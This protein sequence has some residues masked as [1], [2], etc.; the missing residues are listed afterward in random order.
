MDEPGRNHYANDC[1]SEKS[2]CLL[3]SGHLSL[4]TILF[5]R[6]VPFTT[7]GAGDQNVTE[8]FSGPR[9]AID[10]RLKERKNNCAVARWNVAMASRAGLSAGKRLLFTVLTEDQSRAAV[11]RSLRESE[12]LIL[13]SEWM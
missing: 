10:Y 6:F 5:L 7:T 2:K 8:D 9:L 11:L 12:A 4:S 3:N 1:E 13:D